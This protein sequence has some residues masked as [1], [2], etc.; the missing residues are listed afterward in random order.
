MPNSRNRD[1]A[2]QAVWD[3]MKICAIIAAHN[4][5]QIIEATVAR[6]VAALAPQPVFVIADRC[7]D[8]TAARARD[9][10][11]RALERH[12]GPPGKGGAI[13][14]FLNT[15]E[16]VA[17]AADAWLILDAD[18]GLHAGAAAPLMR[19]LN[20]G[21]DAA[22]G[23]VFPVFDEGAPTVSLVAYNEW[24]SQAVD[25]R[26]RSR[27]G[28]PVRLRG[29]G[30]AV[31]AGLL[32]ELA[33]TLRTRVE[34]AEL[35]LLILARGGRI[36][37]A[38]DAVV[39]DP[40]PQSAEFLTKQRARWLQ[41]DWQMWKLYAPTIARLLLTPRPGVWWLLSTLLLKPRSL[42]A[43]AKIVALVVLWPFR[44]YAAARA[45]FWLIALSFAFVIVY[46]LGGLAI[47]PPAWRR[48]LIRSLV[49]APLYVGMWIR[50]FVLGLRTRD[51]WLRARD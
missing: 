51:P 13:A 25:D 46:S 30:M 37:F 1:I 23:F 50:A 29:T 3:V 28:W 14:W 47:A 39:D 35:T 32:R 45:A 5:A 33:P 21:A 34:D 44:E 43:L 8:A 38:P 17:A 31:R 4:E 42:V 12:D 26:L 22:Q 16:A 49:R 19:A 24:M 6:A 18:S 41:G 10:G 11:A 48:P 40:K 27:L 7:D 36:A 15:P 9:A 2:R 20:G